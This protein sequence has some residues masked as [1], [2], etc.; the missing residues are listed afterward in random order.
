MTPDENGN[1]PTS[2]PNETRPERYARHTRNATVFIAIVVGVFA[3]VALYFGIAGVVLL[4]DL[5]S[6]FSN[7][8]NST[9]D[10]N[11]YGG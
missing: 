2:H 4:H 11:S 1:Y 7:I 6:I 3:A 10:P 9:Y 5:N 8:G